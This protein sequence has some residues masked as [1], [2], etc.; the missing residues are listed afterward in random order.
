MAPSG[1]N[2]ERQL[3]GGV[4]FRI[5]SE[6]ALILQRENRIV[7]NIYESGQ[8]FHFKSKYGIQWVE[9]SQKYTYS[10]WLMTDSPP[11][12]LAL[13]IQSKRRAYTETTQAK[14]PPKQGISSRGESSRPFRETKV[15]SRQ[16]FVEA[17]Q[18]YFCLSSTSRLAHSEPCS[19]AEAS[20]MP[21]SEL[22]SCL[23]S[24]IAYWRIPAAPAVQLL[25]V[26]T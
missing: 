23:P 21:P 25:F 12:S 20:T 24:Q 22:G 15:V 8:D 14:M 6:S 1:E 2:R 26:S 7:R 18:P 3:T 13:S 5:D 19:S 9:C 17:N 16:K 4:R 10:K 11:L